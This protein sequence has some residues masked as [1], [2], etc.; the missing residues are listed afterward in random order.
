[1]I[2]FGKDGHTSHTHPHEAVTNGQ[3]LVLQLVFA[4]NL[5]MNQT[6]IQH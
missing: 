1:M 3:S 2:Y 5:H 6:D 4:E